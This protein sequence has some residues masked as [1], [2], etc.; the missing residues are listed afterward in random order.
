MAM[1]PP[2]LR[3]AEVSADTWHDFETLFESKG[4]PSYCWCMTWR[5]T[6]AEKKHTQSDARKQ[7]I[8][9][10]IQEAVPIG[11][12]GYVNDVPVAWCS[13]APRST[14]RRL[15]SDRSPD[16]GTWS[17]TCFFVARSYRHQGIARSML[18]AAVRHARS[19]GAKVVEGYPV[20][21]DSP[22]YRFMGFV[23]TF[24]EAGF[25]ECGREGSRRHVVRLK[26][27]KEM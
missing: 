9:K 22:S 27:T 10:R 13:I 19:K 3:V 17:V 11:L 4:G 18:D 25:H 26:L 21:S 15:V 6:P 16:E 8:Y 1:T 2:P 5:A 20:D 24:A 23:S 7:A 12:I 14:H